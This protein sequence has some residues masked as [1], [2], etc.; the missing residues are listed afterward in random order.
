[1]SGVAITNLIERVFM[2]KPWFPNCSRATLIFDSQSPRENGRVKMDVEY[3]IR[4]SRARPTFRLSV[5]FRDSR[6]EPLIQ[7]AD[8]VAYVVRK[9]YMGHTQYRLFNFQHAFQLLESKIR[10]CPGKN[11]YRG[12]GLKEW[13]I[14]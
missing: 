11:T 4:K 6:N 2:S 10:R 1:M 3:A 12:C 13:V 9:I 7:V 8:Y 5:V 14:K